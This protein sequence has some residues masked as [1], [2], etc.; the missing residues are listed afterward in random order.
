M[1]NDAIKQTA[2]IFVVVHVTIVKYENIAYHFQW[3]YIK[4]NRFNCKLL[5]DNKVY[6]YNK[7]NGISLTVY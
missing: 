2:L 5:A 7:N 1:N 6:W 4:K 3:R